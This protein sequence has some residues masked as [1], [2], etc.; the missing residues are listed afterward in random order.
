MCV[1]GG[2]RTYISSA[3]AVF[4]DRVLDV[5][6]PKSEQLTLYL[7]WLIC[8]SCLTQPPT[9]HSSCAR[10]TN[11]AMLAVWS[12]IFILYTSVLLCPAT[13]STAFFHVASNAHNGFNTDSPVWMRYVPTLL[14]YSIG[15]CLRSF[16]VMALDKSRCTQA[17]YLYSACLK[18]LYS[19]RLD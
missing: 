15:D 2:D 17:G 6:R 4:I 13:T 19:A 8:A 9:L 18:L 7:C 1:G 12:V 16:A 14:W 3:F 10:Y 5:P 11:T